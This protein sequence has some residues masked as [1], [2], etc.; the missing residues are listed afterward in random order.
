M[1]TDE[2]SAEKTA[3]DIRRAT[4]RRY[5]DQEKIHIVLEGLR[6]E[7]S[8]A[9][10]CRCQ[11]LNANIYYRLVEGVLRGWQQAPVGRYTA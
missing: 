4:Q 9:E 5:C 2:R 3:R 7:D 11:G 8:I 10:L 1:M 6:D